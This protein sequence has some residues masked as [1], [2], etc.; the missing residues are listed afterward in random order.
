VT[1]NDQS[2]IGV[3]DST[4]TMI[5]EAREQRDIQKIN[6]A[7]NIVSLLHCTSSVEFWVA[8]WKW[9]QNLPKVFVLKDRSD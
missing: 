9:N 6:F 5:R 7:L 2:S 1:N 8:S 4:V 3:R